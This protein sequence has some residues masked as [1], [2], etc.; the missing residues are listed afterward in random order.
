MSLKDFKEQVSTYALHYGP[1][2]VI[3]GLAGDGIHRVFTGD[4]STG[5]IELLGTAYVFCTRFGEWRKYNPTADEILRQ[6]IKDNDG[7]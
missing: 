7:K 3:G 6:K 5:S 1:E 2:L 4:F